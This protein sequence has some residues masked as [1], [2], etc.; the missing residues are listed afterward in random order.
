[1]SDARVTG[2]GVLTLC[3]WLLIDARAVVPSNSEAVIEVSA[4]L[5]EHVGPALDLAAVKRNHGR[6]LTELA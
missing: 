6:S 3:T 5:T 4:S 1:M 2:G